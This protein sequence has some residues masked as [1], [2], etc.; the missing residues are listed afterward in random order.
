MFF[1]FSLILFPWCEPKK[2]KEKWEIGS[3]D[4]LHIKSLA[5]FP[6]LNTGG[7]CKWASFYHCITVQTLLFAGRDISRMWLRRWADCPCSL[8][9]T[10]QCAGATL[11]RDKSSSRLY[12]STQPSPP[13]PHNPSILPYSC[14][15][16]AL[17]KPKSQL[18]LLL[19]R[20]Q[21]PYV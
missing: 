11:P 1:L 18:S 20:S 10:R 8:L 3:L 7:Y 17:W 13:F 19:P 6:T 5:I 2:L 15:V 21:A 12:S 9:V 14:P 16:L 4:F